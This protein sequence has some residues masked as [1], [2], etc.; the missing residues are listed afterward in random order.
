MNKGWLIMLFFLLVGCNS[1][2]TTTNIDE[3]AWGYEAKYNLQSN[4]KA[5][6][7]VSVE[8]EDGIIF[9]P[10]VVTSTGI[11]TAM[12]YQNAAKDSVSIINANPNE[13]CTFSNLEDCSST[14]IG[15]YGYFRY[16]NRHIYYVAEEMDSKTEQMSLVLR[17]FDLQGQN[18]EK[19][20]TFMQRNILSEEQYGFSYTIHKGYLYYAFDQDGIY[21]I[22]M[23]N[24]EEEEFV[25]FKGADEIRM[26]FYNDTAYIN[27]NNFK[28]G[29]TLH[30][31]AIYKVN[32]NNNTREV[33]LEGISAYHIDEDN[34]IY[35]QEDPPSTYIYNFKTEEH[36]KIV[37]NFI[38]WVY[39]INNYYVIDGVGM[40]EETAGNIYLID[41]LGNTLD[42]IESPYDFHTMSQGV[43][44]N[45]YY[46]YVDDTFMYFPIIDNKFGELQEVIYEE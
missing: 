8:V 15:N 7:Q 27:V 30:S 43:I 14:K 16:F 34:I 36:N 24:F 35:V 20:F 12:L 31:E 33:L 1:S 37:D 3:D 23:E 2:K 4:T 42:S 40:S 6:M 5:A 17:R 19:L 39:R 44:N 10:S 25:D 22:N 32:L 26:F 38:A 45:R 18:E 11:K 9:F 28:D 21:K 41:L 29:D 46:I 13:V